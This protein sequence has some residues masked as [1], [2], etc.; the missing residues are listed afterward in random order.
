MT[1]YHPHMPI[2]SAY[3]A[4]LQDEFCVFLRDKDA[5]PY[6][7][8]QRRGSLANFQEVAR[9]LTHHVHRHERFKFVRGPYFTHP[10]WVATRMNSDEEVVT[11][12]LHD[13]IETM[14]KLL[15]KKIAKI[16]PPRDFDTVTEERCI[17]LAGQVLIGHFSRHGYD[18]PALFPH[19]LAN[20]NALTRRESEKDNYDAYGNRLIDYADTTGQIIVLKVKLAD[21]YHNK[22][23]ER[24]RRG[25]RLTPDDLDRL[26]NYQRLINK[27]LAKHP[28]IELKDEPMSRP[29][30]IARDAKH[31][32]HARKKRKR[33]RKEN[34]SRDKVNV[35]DWREH[36]RSFPVCAL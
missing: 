8:E 22:K 19:M 36:H 10:E 20:L 28:D 32:G 27:I 7:F 25:S 15:K 24:N 35:E 18:I 26:D 29:E 6:L 12:L 16:E 21:L 1:S 31:G 2:A 30:R 5:F 3:P 23:R 14:V 9:E 13:S 4:Y 17:N 34:N 33:N 11:A